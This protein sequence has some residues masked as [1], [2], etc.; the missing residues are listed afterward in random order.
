M[1]SFEKLAKLMA[2][3]DPNELNQRAKESLPDLIEKLIVA[4]TKGS[5]SSVIMLSFNM[6]EAHCGTYCI[7]TTPEEVVDI[8]VDVAMALGADLERSPAPENVT[9]Q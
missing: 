2:E 3:T 5:K 9:L 4:M 7:N 1:N 8:L 6:E